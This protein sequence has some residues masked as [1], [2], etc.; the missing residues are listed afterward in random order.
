MSSFYSYASHPSFTNALLTCLLYVPKCSRGNDCVLN[1]EV[2]MTVGSSPFNLSFQFSKILLK[3]IVQNRSFLMLLQTPLGLTRCMYLDFYWSF[4]S[5][6]R[7]FAF[8]FSLF[9]VFCLQSSGFKI[10]LCKDLFFLLSAS[11]T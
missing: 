11:F 2:E 8:G 10:Y 9:V 6:K 1:L 5:G 7:V 3:R 4:Y